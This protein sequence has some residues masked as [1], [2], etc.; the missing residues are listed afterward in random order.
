MPTLDKNP[1]A[2]K[3]DTRVLAK[4][5]EGFTHDVRKAI[6]DEAK[7]TAEKALEDGADTKHGQGRLY[8]TLGRPTTPEEQ[9]ALVTCIETLL[10]STEP[11]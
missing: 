3:L 6:V 11:S 7:K 9:A 1:K 2:P 4:H 8:R 10:A 5:V